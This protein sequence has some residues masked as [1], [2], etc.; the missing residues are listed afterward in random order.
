MQNTLKQLFNLIISAKEG[1]AEL[2][3]C[4]KAFLSK[5]EGLVRYA[6]ESI[7][8]MKL[9]EYANTVIFSIA[10]EYKK[11]QSRVSAKELAAVNKKVM[12]RWVA[13]LAPV[14]PH[15]AEELWAKLGNEDYVSIAEWPK[16]DE[17][18]INM[19]LEFG[20][21][22][23][24]NT[25]ADIAAIEKLVGKKPERITIFVAEEWKNETLRLITKLIAED[26]RDFKTIIEVLMKDEKIRPHGG[27]ITKI[28]PKILKDVS[29]IP[30]IILGSKAEKEILED[31]KE[32]FKKEFNCKVEI[33][34]AENQGNKPEEQKARQAMPGKPA[35][36]FS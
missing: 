13:L 31:A 12:G 20:E 18:A 26:K 32:F 25:A 36:L 27:E 28:L 35:I 8:Q 7:K 23:I 29:K 15:I 11:L 3:T 5:F 9:R 2:S 14:I 24:S 33:L 16:C 21:E 17:K 4:S 30:G 6:T 19:E 22:L 34:S 10:N 1:K